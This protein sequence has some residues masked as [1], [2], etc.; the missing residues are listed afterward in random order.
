L[1]VPTPR[2]MR[3]FAATVLPLALAS[4]MLP[5]G[6]SLL[7]GISLLLCAIGGADAWQAGRRMRGINVEFPERFNLSCNRQ[8]GLPFRVSDL[9]GAPRSLVIALQL[10][11][12]ITSPCPEYPLQLSGEGQSVR[13][14]WPVTASLRGSHLLEQCRLRLLSPLGLWY[15]QTPLPA[16]TRIRAY[17]NLGAERKRLAALFLNRNTA[18]VRPARQV[19]QGREFEKLRLYIPGDSIGDI[20]WRATA[21]RGHPVTK[22]F[23]IERTQEVY[24]IIDA[25]RLSAREVAPRSGEGITEPLLERYILSALILGSV[26]RKQGDLFGVMA[27]SDQVLGF[28]RAKS[29]AGHFGACRDAIFNL[30]PAT[31]NPGYEEAASFLAARLRRRALLIFL[32]SLDEPALAEGFV[33][34]IGVLSRR[35]LVCVAM[36]RPEAAV[37]LFSGG[38]AQGVDDIYRS[39]GGHIVWH[40]LREMKQTLRLAGVQLSLVEDERMSAEVVSRYLDVKRRQML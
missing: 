5:N 38:E 9:S 4:A 36:Q 1:I 6:F 26:A 29:G 35:H 17:P 19:G 18:L 10:P 40:G 25:S 28:V 15:A 23:R 3:L 34:S 20:H 31:V 11:G 27:F 32:T 33:R 12:G 39:L 7:C 14:L 22:E 13:G 30:A 37:P 2:I 24:V 21:K 16:G 8:A